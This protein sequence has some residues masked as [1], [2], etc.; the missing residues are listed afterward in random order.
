MARKREIAGGCD[1]GEHEALADVVRK[2]VHGAPGSVKAEGDTE[3][4][5]GQREANVSNA[6]QTSSGSSS[7]MESLHSVRRSRPPRCS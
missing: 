6:E 1:L 2:V 5:A 7:K 4:G 3:G